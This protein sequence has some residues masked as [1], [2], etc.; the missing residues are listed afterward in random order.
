MHGSECGET[1]VVGEEVV[2]TAQSRSARGLPETSKRTCGESLDGLLIY[3]PVAPT[4]GA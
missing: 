3:S 4:V 2:C 1:G